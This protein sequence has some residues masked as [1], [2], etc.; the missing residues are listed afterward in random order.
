MLGIM[1]DIA[2]V[3]VPGVAVILIA[4]TGRLWAKGKKKR[5]KEEGTIRLYSVL[6]FI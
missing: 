3:V 2:A 1:N 6:Y 4:A 5:I